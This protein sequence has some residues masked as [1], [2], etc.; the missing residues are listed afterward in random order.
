MDFSEFERLRQA[1]KGIS[2]ENQHILGEMEGLKKHNAKLAILVKKSAEKIL[3]LEREASQLRAE[4]AELSRKNEENSKLDTANRL[5][6][7]RS[8]QK[9]VSSAQTE[10]FMKRLK[11]ELASK[12]GEIRTLRTA[13]VSSGKAIS[14]LQSGNR[15]I[16]SQAIM[17]RQQLEESKNSEIERAKEYRETLLGAQ[18]SAGKY[19]D[20]IAKIKSSLGSLLKNKVVSEAEKQKLKAKL[21]EL[22]S[23][24]D[25]LLIKEEYYKQVILSLTKKQLEM[26]SE[27]EVMKSKTSEP[28]IAEGSLRN[29]VPNNNRASKNTNSN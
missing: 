10:K 2:E 11:E 24:K 5:L 19:K 23:V 13:L 25:E 9:E 16:A 18:K 8:M 14:V 15:K 20:Q 26:D 6:A 27:I 3:N 17:F 1:N 22:S 7:K 21:L 28:G 4:S 29:N 12:A